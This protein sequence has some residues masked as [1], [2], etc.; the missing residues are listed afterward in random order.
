VIAMQDRGAGGGGGDFGENVTRT[1]SISA[2]DFAALVQTLRYGPARPNRWR[3]L[4]RDHSAASGCFEGR[5]S[6]H[7]LGGPPMT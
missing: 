1:L 5:G 3:I 2:K 4:Q 7:Q 6:E